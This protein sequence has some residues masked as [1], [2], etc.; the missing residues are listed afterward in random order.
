MEPELIQLFD[1]HPDW[2]AFRVR[3]EYQALRSAATLPADPHRGLFV[4]I[5]CHAFYETA[6]VQDV[7]SKLVAARIC[8]R[9]V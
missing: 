3:E 2:H 8:R 1:Q 7:A 4:A 9:S 5:Y 6:A